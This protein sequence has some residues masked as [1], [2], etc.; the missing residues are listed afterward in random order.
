MGIFKKLKD[1]LEISTYMRT[2]HKLAKYGNRK[3]KRG[4]KLFN[5]WN[6][7]SIKKYGID[8]RGTF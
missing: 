5:K 2:G 1:K 8:T 4:Q 3:D 6:N 7:R